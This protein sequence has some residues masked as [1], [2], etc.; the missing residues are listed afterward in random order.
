[1]NYLK[2]SRFPFAVLSLVFASLASASSQI[3]VATQEGVLFEVKSPGNRT[4]YLAGSF[5]NWA[6]NNEGD[7]MNDRYAM[8]RGKNSTWSKVMKLEPGRYIFKFVQER[9]A[10]DEWFI[11]DGTPIVDDE[12]NAVFTVAANGDVYLGDGINPALT[13]KV[14]GDRVTF[15][16]WAP[17]AG[18]VYLAGDF[19]NWANNQEGF[20]SMVSAQMSGP[21]D[22]GVW[23]K[24]VELS[25]GENHYQFVIDGEHWIRDPN[26][27]EYVSDHSII[28]IK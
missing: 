4:V 28:E 23:R 21:D 13:P 9:G 14:D 16:L 20:V 5:N 11:P 6:D 1:M 27:Q 25:S 24:T 3:P 8:T 26:E 12:G 10:F 2:I 17:D 22:N 15:Q 18:M 7:V 19:N